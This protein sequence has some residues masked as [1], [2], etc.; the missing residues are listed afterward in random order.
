MDYN[1]LG[2][3]GVGA[4]II[5]VLGFV[6]R[7]VN[8]KRV[9]SA[10][11]GRKL[12]VSLDIEDTTPQSHGAVGQPS[13]A[14][15]HPPPA[16]T[17]PPSAEPQQSAPVSEAQSEPQPQRPENCPQGETPALLPPSN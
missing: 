3:G 11:C 12:E 16:D 4:G 17:K 5:V 15:Q 13:S 8:H 9:R 1:S 7:L 6:Y 10:C 2:A 14:S